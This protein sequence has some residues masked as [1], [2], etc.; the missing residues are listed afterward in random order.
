METTEEPEN[1]LEDIGKENETEVDTGEEISGQT[2]NDTPGSSTALAKE[3]IEYVEDREKQDPDNTDLAGDEND[4]GSNLDLEGEISNEDIKTLAENEEI[5]ENNDNDN[6]LDLEEPLGET[7]E[8]ENTSEKSDIVRQEESSTEK[9]EELSENIEA[10]TD[11]NK[12]G[13]FSHEGHIEG[14]EQHTGIE[15]KD[16]QESADDKPTETSV[17]YKETLEIDSEKRTETTEMIGTE[18]TVNEDELLYMDVN[19]TQ[20]MLNAKTHL[21]YISTQ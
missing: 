13:E 1:C 16:T 20:G 5:N 8:T 18:E 15:N 14:D 12:F 9:D 7:E 21:F 4:F 17:E 6:I 2:E 10:R 11:S 3:N 19:K